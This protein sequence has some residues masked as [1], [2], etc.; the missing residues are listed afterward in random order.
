MQPKEHRGKYISFLFALTL[1]YGKME[2]KNGELMSIK[3]HIPLFGQ[4]MRYEEHLDMMK[5]RLAQ[6]GIFITASTVRNNDG[7]VYQISCND[8]EVL[9]NFAS[10]AKGIEKID[11]IPKY[12]LTSEYKKSLLE[13]IANN[14]EIPAEGKDEAIKKI[15]E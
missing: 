11:K 7:M 1:L 8:Y 10:Y 15:K 5:K 6:E 4:F 3:I 2:S 14:P 9:K 12:D 13:F